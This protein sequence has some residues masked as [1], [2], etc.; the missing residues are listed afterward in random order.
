MA[1]TNYPFRSSPYQTCSVSTI[2]VV[3]NINRA[4]ADLESIRKKV[5]MLLKK[6]DLKGCKTLES[7]LKKLL[8]YYYRN[9]HALPTLQDLS[10]YTT[11]VEVIDLTMDD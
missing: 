8:T 10:L 3:L 6:N 4:D 5:K 2:L 1:R 7:S 11:F 9:D